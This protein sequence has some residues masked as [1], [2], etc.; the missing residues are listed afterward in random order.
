MDDLRRNRYSDIFGPDGK[1]QVTAD[2]RN[3]IKTISTKN[4]GFSKIILKNDDEK[5]YHFNIE[6]K[7][8][9]TLRFIEKPKIPFHKNEFFQKFIQKNLN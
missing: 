7:K 6:I 8:L 1:C 4:F 2:E 9:Q 5:I 3:N